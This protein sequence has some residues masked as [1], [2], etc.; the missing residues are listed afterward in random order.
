MAF[1]RSPTAVKEDP[2]L[3]EAMA[4][5]LFVTWGVGSVLGFS[6]GGGIHALLLLAV[7][8]FLIDRRK[9]ARQAARA[10]LSPAGILSIVTK[11]AP[12]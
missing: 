4:F 6:F 5:V 3:L 2:G 8:I 1:G 10:Q 11:S 7:S 12:L 9:R